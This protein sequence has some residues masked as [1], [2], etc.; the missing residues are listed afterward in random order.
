MQ[1]VQRNSV[2][3]EILAR[4]PRLEAV[5]SQVMLVGGSLFQTVWNV[6][7]DEPPEARIRD[8][9][10]FYWEADTSYQAEDYAI[11]QAEELF[12]DLPAE[13][14]LRNQARVHLWF[15]EK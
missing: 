14:Q 8:Y 4:L 1:L 10:L 2:N 11:R 15:Q 9:D 3:A 5:A 7:S 12:R 13:I 6:L